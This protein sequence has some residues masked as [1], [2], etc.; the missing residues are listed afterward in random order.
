MIFVVFVVASLADV[1]MARHVSKKGVTKPWERMVWVGGYFCCF[2]NWRQSFIYSL[3]LLSDEPVLQQKT[4]LD[5]LC[6]Y[7]TKK[8]AYGRKTFSLLVAFISWPDKK[9]AFFSFMFSLLLYLQ[10][11]LIFLHSS[12][13]SV[14]YTAW[15]A[16]KQITP[17]LLHFS[18]SNK[19]A[20]FTIPPSLHALSHWWDKSN[21][22]WFLRRANKWWNLLRRVI[23]VEFVCS[24]KTR[25]RF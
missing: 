21:F 15:E 6:L 5:T 4:P 22:T 14:F 2:L 7:L 17:S 16:E 18:W 20:F 25:G 12:Q 19:P 11:A 24:L 13:K 23:V 1:L 3:G 10:S 9:L 8:L